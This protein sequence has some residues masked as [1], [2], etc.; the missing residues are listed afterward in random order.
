MFSKLLQSS[1][2]RR[3]LASTSRRVT[4]RLEHQIRSLVTPTWR[5]ALPVKTIDVRTDSGDMILAFYRE[6]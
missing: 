1:G 4:P 6:E 5:A 3:L 2:G